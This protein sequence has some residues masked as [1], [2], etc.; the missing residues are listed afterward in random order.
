[1]AD[2]GKQHWLVRKPSKNQHKWTFLLGSNYPF[3]DYKKIGF[4]RLETDEG[5]EIFESLNYTEQERRDRRQP[6]LM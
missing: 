2:V 1:M 4:I 6:R 5:A 3:K